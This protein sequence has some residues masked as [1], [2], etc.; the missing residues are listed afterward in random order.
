MPRAC[1]KT[2]AAA[3]DALHIYRFKVNNV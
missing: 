1:S 3:A 2:S